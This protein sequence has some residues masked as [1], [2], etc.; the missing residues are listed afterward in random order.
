MKKTIL[1]GLIAAS[2]AFDA[3][4]LTSGDLAFTSFNADE[5]GW[6]LVTFTNIA[7]N[8]TLFFSDNEWNGSA[9]GGGGAFNSG[10]S[11][12]KWVSGAGIINAGT[13]IRFSATDKTTLS[14]SAGTLQ[15]ETVAGSANYGT[16]NSNE[17]IYVYQ[18]S[19]STPTSFIT[20]ITNGTFTAD[21]SIGGTGLIEGSTALRLNTLAPGATPDYAE[22]TGIRSGL[23][24]YAGYK[25]LVANMANWNVDTTNGTYTTTVPNTTAFT[26]SPVPEPESWAMLLVGVGLVGMAAR[27]KFVAG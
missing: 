26:I 10:E 21:G 3:N 13:V 17:T 2:A 9:I 4:A 23:T 12:H 1:A 22:Y 14:A 25:P 7:A 19:A 11:F 16:A 20:A 24:T 5:D 27:R 6:S 8:T 18:G 15:R